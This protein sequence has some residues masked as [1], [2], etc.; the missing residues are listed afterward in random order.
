MH[1]H[2]SPLHCFSYFLTY[3]D[4]YHSLICELFSYLLVA[5]RLSPGSNARYAPGLWSRARG[6]DRRFPG[7]PD[8]AAAPRTRPGVRVYT[9]TDVST[10]GWP[11]AVWTG[12]AK[13]SQ[14]HTVFVGQ[15]ISEN[16][17]DLISLFHIILTSALL[18]T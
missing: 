15:H 13:L 17:W 8:A 7:T 1:K 2:L 16:T 18:Y 10:T 3:I 9:T 6:S 5:A 11:D 12:E 14:N 4:K